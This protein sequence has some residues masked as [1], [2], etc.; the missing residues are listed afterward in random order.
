[1]PSA[2]GERLRALREADDSRD[3]AL[4]EADLGLV[5]S[6]PGADPEGWTDVRAAYDAGL[7]VE[8]LM[9]ER[10]ES[11]NLRVP[12][13][14][15]DDA[16]LSAAAILEGLKAAGATTWPALV[17][18]PKQSAEEAEPV[19][20]G[21]EG[22]EEAE[23]AEDAQ[24]EVWRVPEDA[25]DGMREELLAF[26]AGLAA[27][28]QADAAELADDASYEG[29]LYSGGVP[30]PGRIAGARETVAA[31]QRMHASGFLRDMEAKV[32]ATLGRDWKSRD[33]FYDGVRE[34]FEQSERR[35]GLYAVG[36]GQ[37]AWREGVAAGAESRGSKGAVWVCTFA[38]HSCP[39]CLSLHG[40]WFTWEELRRIWGTT[41]CRNNCLC[42]MAPA[43]DPGDVLPEDMPEG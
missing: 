43:D 33:D 16:G 38:P 14:A 24:R 21:E 2:L 13:Q 1:M 41:Q 17:Y 12:A 7:H 32:E 40:K 42:G 9:L 37:P 23:A 4:V 35:A 29:Y 22:V 18:Q 28:L 19:A 6:D 10:D 26:A 31:V 3:W 20:E 15:A 39:D 27:V 11:G 8:P 34:F 5:L 36:G 25:K 30:S